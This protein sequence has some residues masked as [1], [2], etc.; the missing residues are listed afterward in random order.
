ML[1]NTGSFICV[2]SWLHLLLR[3][4][5]NR[6]R[7]WTRCSF[8]DDSVRSFFL[9]NIKSE[10]TS[11]VEMIGNQ[12]SYD[13]IEEFIDN[14]ANKIAE[15]LFQFL[16][17]NDFEICMKEWC[18]NDIPI[19]EKVDDIKKVIYQ[20]IDDRFVCLLTLWE[21]ENGLLRQLYDQVRELLHL[22]YGS[23]VEMLEG[24]EN[25]LE[26]ENY[27]L[28]DLHD[29]HI[30][31]APKEN[32]SWKN[33][34]TS[35][36]IITGTIGGGAAGAA[37]GITVAEGVT[38]AVIGGV[39]GGVTGGIGIIITAVVIAAMAG[40]VWSVTGASR[41]RS[42]I[43]SIIQDNAPDFIAAIAEE[44]QAKKIVETYTKQIKES[45]KGWRK[46]I[47]KHLN[48]NEFL[49]DEAKVKDFSQAGN[50]A[51]DKIDIISQY[52]NEISDVL[53]LYDCEI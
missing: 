7:L 14:N 49:L 33:F 19:R 40:Y 48:A 11:A 5:A 29:L 10:I 24:L 39:I 37:I 46:Q 21:E 35:V 22:R 30:G 52:T 44:N 2:Y 34:Y 38:A 25:T 50:I 18:L 32:K 36:G 13:G 17:S 6:Y 42:Q 12:N 28:N 43:L 16:R 45:I 27:N 20:L 47:I 23:V 8:L 1:T 3:I 26:I 31:T 41:Q 51:S 9:G 53:K 4:V 15:S